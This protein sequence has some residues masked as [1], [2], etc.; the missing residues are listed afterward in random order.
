MIWFFKIILKV[1]FVDK[2]LKNDQSYPRTVKIWLQSSHVLTMVTNYSKFT[3]VNIGI[4][5]KD[6]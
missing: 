6:P 3:P 5:I 4:N 2:K 1:I